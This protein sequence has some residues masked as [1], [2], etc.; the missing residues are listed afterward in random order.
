MITGLLESCQNYVVSKQSNLTHWHPVLGWFAQPMDSALH[1][2]IPHVKIQLQLLWNT[3][4]INIL[5]GI[6]NKLLYL[7]RDLNRKR[8]TEKPLILPRIDP[9]IFEYFEPKW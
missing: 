4:M 5:L 6:N 2:A 7:I 3:Q 8:N 9:I 1:A